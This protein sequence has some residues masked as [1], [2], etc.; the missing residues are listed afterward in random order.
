LHRSAEPA[1][2]GGTRPRILVL[3]AGFGEG[4]NAAA[5]AIA[6]A[7]D[8]QAGPGTARLVDLFALATPRLNALTRQAY[9]GAINRTP[10][11]WGRLY[12]WLDASDTLPR[13]IGRMGRPRRRLAALLAAEQ[14]AVVCSTFPA[15]A[16]L[17]QELAKAGQFD[18]PHYTV[19]TDSISVNSLW[20]RA[21]STGW[22]LPNEDSADVL[23]RAG[24][25]P[26][27]L[28]VHGFPVTS[29]FA[30]QAERFRPP[31]LA[32]GA[33]PRVLF[34]VHSGTRHA[35][36]T[37][38]LLL[39]EPGWDITCTVGR[40][41]GLRRRLSA[42]AARQGRGAEVLGWTDQIPRLLMTQH[43][44]VSKAGGATTQESIA[45]LCPMIVN[46]IVPGQE[47]GNYELLRRHGAGALAE[48]PEAVLA[49]LRRAFAH[50]GAGWRQ[51]RSAL[52]P[53]ARPA[54]ATTIADFLLQ[55]P[56]RS[57]PAAP[58][59]ATNGGSE[60]PPTRNP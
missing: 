39:A 52:E 56:R 58:G 40:N 54:A 12:R 5:R 25:D 16:L 28:H 42:V 47:E 43:V 17:L 27:R 19:V 37:A 24:V 20:W 51:W 23:R 46:Q 11:L 60:R 33:A 21:P 38:R 30:R 1:P 41:A 13:L 4:H 15:Y 53:L 7:C 14:P 44:V 45:A 26:A 31:D 59:G 8:D 32:T 29:F 2:G 35:E 22:F 10:R 50:G 9:F 18:A 49:C 6:A 57:R 36:A 48:T 3:T 34:I 55:A